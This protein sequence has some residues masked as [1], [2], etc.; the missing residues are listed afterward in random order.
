ME[1]MFS[2]FQILL[3]NKSEWRIGASY[4]KM[5]LYVILKGMDQQRISPFNLKDSTLLHVKNRG[6]GTQNSQNICAL[7]LPVLVALCSF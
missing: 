5:L 7:Q 1:N 3:C 6:T 2:T 4:Q